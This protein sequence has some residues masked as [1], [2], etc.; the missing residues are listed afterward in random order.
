MKSICSPGRVDWT[1]LY[2]SCKRPRNSVTTKDLLQQELGTWVEGCEASPA[3][4]AAQNAHWTAA[5]A[6]Y[7]VSEEV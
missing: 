2:M 3:I 7:H 5:E 1:A 6:A 4:G